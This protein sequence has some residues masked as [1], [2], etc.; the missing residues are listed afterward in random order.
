MVSIRFFRTLSFIPFSL[1]LNFFS[2][3]IV[4]LQSEYFSYFVFTWRCLPWQSS[5]EHFPAKM[6]YKKVVYE[7]CYLT[8]KHI[9][10]F[11]IKK[12]LFALKHFYSNN[13]E[14]HDIIFLL[15]YRYLQLKSWTSA[16]LCIL[17]VLAPA[18]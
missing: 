4:M 10:S 2:V 18:V 15:E 14:T 3:H 7:E 9:I 1:S 16:S 6:R 13:M 11:S 8:G 5:D 17:L 12:L